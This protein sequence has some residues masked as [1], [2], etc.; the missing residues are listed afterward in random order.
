[1]S[2]ENV[3]LVRRACSAVPRG[4]DALRP[5]IAPDFVW[6]TAPGWPGEYE[7]RGVEGVRVFFEEWVASLGAIGLE[8]GEIRAVGDDVLVLAEVSGRGA[9]SGVPGAWR[10]GMIYADFRGGRI[11]ELRTFMR[12]EEA[13]KAVGLEE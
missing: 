2:Q 7:Y 4:F 9:E 10:F 13:L 3:E 6:R 12:W 5:F 1:M 11:G 8:I